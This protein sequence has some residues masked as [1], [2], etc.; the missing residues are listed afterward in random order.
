MYNLLENDVSKQNVTFC[1]FFL[2]ES[3]LIVYEFKLGWTSVTIVHIFWRSAGLSSTM[4]WYI[5]RPCGDTFKQ[6]AYSFDWIFSD[7]IHIIIF[8]LQTWWSSKPSKGR[9]RTENIGRIKHWWT[10]WHWFKWWFNKWWAF[11]LINITKTES[12]SN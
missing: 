4:C 8:F 7:K 9:I 3:L 10:K 2:V 6:V 5:E 12:P 1:I 11:F